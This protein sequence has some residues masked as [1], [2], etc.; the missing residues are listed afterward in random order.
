MLFN[1]EKCRHLASKH[2]A[3][4]GL[5]NSACQFLIYSTFVVLI[6]LLHLCARN[7]NFVAIKVEEL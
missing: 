4:A 1:A 3:S 7:D 6:I 2:E 5:Y